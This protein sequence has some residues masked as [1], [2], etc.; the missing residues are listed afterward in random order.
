MMPAVLRGL[1]DSAPS[2]RRPRDGAKSGVGR[3]EPAGRSSPRRILETARLIAVVTGISAC[4]PS[5]QSIY[6]GN[7][8]FEH[9]YRLDLDLAIAPT[10]RE[11][12]W[13]QWLK[14]YTFGQP[15]DRTEYA[16]RRVRAFTSGDLS[17]PRLE[18]GTERRPEERPFYLVVPS[19]TSPHSSPPPIAP[20]V[21]PEAS[22]APRNTASAPATPA[23]SCVEACSSAWKSCQGACGPDG[24]AS[25]MACKSCEPDYKKCMKRCFE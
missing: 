6:E 24:G 4:G 23:A 25:E 16:R 13:R 7:V 2:V 14:S 12:C 9:C 11:A 3:R 17:R 15:R 5:F 10:H 18:L 19:P 20:P 21:Q 22:A 8:R 1:A